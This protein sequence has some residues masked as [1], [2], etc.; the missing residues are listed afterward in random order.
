MLLGYRE[1]G[2]GFRATPS[3]PNRR[4]TWQVPFSFC[5][6]WL[7]ECA[8]L[9]STSAVHIGVSNSGFMKRR[10]EPAAASHWVK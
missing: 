10:P 4:T 3:T 6:P 5:I 9:A 8:S 1:S 7:V 2:L